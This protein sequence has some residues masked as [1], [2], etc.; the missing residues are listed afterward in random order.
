MDLPSV[1]TV[2]TGGVIAS[3]LAATVWLIN[4]FSGL[5]TDGEKLADRRI[6]ALTRDFDDYR[7]RTTAE[8]TAVHEQLVVLR[9]AQR[10]CLED[11]AAMTVELIS[12]RAELARMQHP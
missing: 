8:L 12:V 4:W 1:E 9:E 2:A 10:R 11:S 3:V 6:A 5:A 7:A